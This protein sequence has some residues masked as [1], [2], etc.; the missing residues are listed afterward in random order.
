MV[1]CKWCAEP[2]AKVCLP[3]LVLLNGERRRTPSNHG[4]RPQ[5]LGSRNTLIVGDCTSGLHV[6]HNVLSSA[7]SDHD[8]LHSL[9][10]V[11]CNSR[12]MDVSGCSTRPGLYEPT[13][14]P[15][16]DRTNDR[17]R[18]KKSP[19]IASRRDRLVDWNHRRTIHTFDFWPS[20]ENRPLWLEPAQGVRRVAR[21]PPGGG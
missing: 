3:G 11:G 13:V 7:G 18:S 16:G 19:A 20:T 17:H 5:W 8:G 2:N 15:L 10:G 21:S 12:E 9:R 4:S 1:R 14:R 6:C